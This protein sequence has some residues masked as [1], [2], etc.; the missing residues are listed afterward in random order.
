M[1]IYNTNTNKLIEKAAGE[2]K[3]EIKAPEW[4]IFVKTGHGRDRLPENQDW[5]HMRAASILRKVYIDGPIGVSKL[6]TKYGN[7]KNRG[8]KPEKFCKSSGKIIR[9]LLQQLEEKGFIEKAEKGVHKGRAITGKGKSFLDRLA[10]GKELKKQDGTRE[11]K[12]EEN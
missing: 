6:R 9:V 5:W 12:K 3:K 10:L 11:S 7:K 8:H 4:S 2:L 1:S